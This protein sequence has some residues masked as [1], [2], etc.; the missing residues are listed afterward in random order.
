M[1][2]L[3]LD[4]QTLLI[5]MVFV[6]LLTAGGSLLVW[7]Q[8]RQRLEVFWI[9]V[10]GA[11]MSL[12]MIGRDS[13]PSQAA[14]AFTNFA[15]LFSFGFFW[16]AF[17]CLRGYQPQFVI[18]IAPALIWLGLYFIPEFRVSFDLRLG[19]SLLLL[20]IPMSL[21]VR[22]L[23]LTPTSSAI[24]RWPLLVILGIQ[25]II[26]L[27][28]AV[29]SL[30]WPRIFYG[31]FEVVPGFDILIIDL[32]I[33]MLVG[34]FSIIALVKE[35]AVRWHHDNARFDFL[36]NVGNRLYFEECLLRH[37]QRATK[38]SQSLALIMIDADSFK[39]Y[40]DLYGH[41]AGDRCLK[42]LASALVASCRPTDIVGRYGGEEFAVLLPNTDMKA[43]LAIAE[44]MLLQVRN[45]RIPH[46]NRP[47]GIMTISL[48]V[49]AVVPEPGNKAPINLVE[50]AD[51]ALYRAKDEGRDRICGTHLA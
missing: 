20:L 7:L 27:Q 50:A 17:R 28:R 38:T 12:A 46:A 5:A 15:L 29:R 34:N 24:I 18:I 42:M 13:L 36:T 11:M 19:L 10:S 45:M 32:T 49:A 51:Q 39:E 25:L 33:I 4:P 30:M 44:R 21:T 40:N 37:F 3:N 47:D 48:G 9:A 2:P 16:T 8:D 35:K 26:M 22:E 31:S 41:P 43:A 14:V 1:M 6:T 23:S